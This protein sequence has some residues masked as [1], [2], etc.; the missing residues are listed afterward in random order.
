[1]GIVILC[2]WGSRH[3]RKSYTRCLVFHYSPRCLKWCIRWTRWPSTEVRVP[4]V[5]HGDSSL[6]CS[7]RVCYSQTCTVS[8]IPQENNLFKF[9]SGSTRAESRVR[10]ASIAQW[11]AIAR[12][13][14]H[15]A[16][17]QVRFPSGL[18]DSNP[19]SCPTCAC[20]FPDLHDATSEIP[21]ENN[22][23]GVLERVHQDHV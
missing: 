1:M 17:T 18:H 7:T 10:H 12:R 3:S 16:P 14:W 20:C 5:P 19:L 23:S 2:N 21:Q 8:E 13:L 15:R 11:T 4:S 6:V 22:L 9:S